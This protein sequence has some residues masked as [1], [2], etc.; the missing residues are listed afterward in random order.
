V[1]Q[2]KNQRVSALNVARQSGD[3]AYLV[4][5]LSDPEDRDIAAMLLGKMGA[6]DAIPQLMR[7][8][9]VA[10]PGTRS[11]AT[12][13]LIRLDA[14]DALP[15]LV[16]MAT[17]DNS[18]VVRSHAVAAVRKLGEPAQAVPVLLEAL[19]D[20]DGGVSAGA[21][22]ELGVVA[23]ATAIEPIKSAAVGAVFLRRYFYRRAIRRIRRRSGT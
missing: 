14:R 7:L 11:S 22:E 5:A 12:K 9:S 4:D 23:D 13:A 6:T 3:V 21:A 18:P 16:R 17:T 8:L 2:T 1:A 10:A 19:R 20:P 15:E